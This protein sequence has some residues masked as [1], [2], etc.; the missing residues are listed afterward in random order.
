[1]LKSLSCISSTNA[2]CRREPKF[3]TAKRKKYQ[4]QLADN[5]VSV[6][7]DSQATGEQGERPGIPESDFILAL[8]WT[9]KFFASASVSASQAK[10]SLSLM[11]LLKFIKIPV[12][13]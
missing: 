1:M 9:L 12:A 2:V 13:L 6:C 8:L 4:G 5:F 7:L 10:S 3:L 11:D